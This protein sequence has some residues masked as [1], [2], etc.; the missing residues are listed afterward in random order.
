V[1]VM[2]T[3][4]DHI[5]LEARMMQVKMEN[6]AR[7][8]TCGQAGRQAGKE[9]WVGPVGSQACMG[10]KVWRAGSKQAWVRRVWVVRGGGWGGDKHRHRAAAHAVRACPRQG[11]RLGVWHQEEGQE[12][13]QGAGDHPPTVREKTVWNMRPPLS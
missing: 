11:G 1:K 12:Q 4:A 9:A 13:E 6:T 8:A 3:T 7:V 10:G 2:M 5:F